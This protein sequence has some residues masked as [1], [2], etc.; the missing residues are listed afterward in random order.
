M[1]RSKKIR[2]PKFFL[3][4]WYLDIVEE[5]GNVLILYAAIL[6]WYGFSIPYKRVLH[7]DNIKM[8]EQAEFSSLQ[9]P[10]IKDNTISWEDRSLKIAGSW[11]QMTAGIS[12]QLMH[13]EEG[14]LRWNCFPLNDAQVTWKGMPMLGKGY[15]DQILMTIAPWK[16]GLH[17]LI[18]GRFISDEHF[19]V[20][21][22]I[23]L[24]NTR[25]KWLWYNGQA[26]ENP[27]IEEN[28]ISVPEKG[29]KLFISM[30]VPLTKGRIIQ[31]VMKGIL[32]FIP[33]LS[34]PKKFLSTNELKFR[35]RGELITKD[36]TIFRGWVI[37]ERVQFY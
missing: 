9:L 2:P 27:V 37:H 1:K 12:Q 23:D 11:S 33:F 30:E 29:L 6:K 19:L 25:S 32:S 13:T 24:E 35:A 31:Q 10:E 28:F 14:E 18:W 17:S 21:I 20:W 34:F 26:L 16:M 3:D 8:A 22:Q 4:K 7:Y 36:D 5:K 15:A